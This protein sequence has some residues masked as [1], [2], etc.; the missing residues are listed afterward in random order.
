[1]P[2]GWHSA[3][4]RSISARPK[5]EFHPDSHSE[6]G[7]HRLMSAQQV[8]AI[9]ARKVGV[10]GFD[11]KG[12]SLLVRAQLPNAIIVGVAESDTDHGGAGSLDD[13]RRP[14]TVAV[15]E[16]FAVGRQQ[17][18]QSAFLLRPRR[19]GRRRTRGVRGRGW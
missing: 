12:D 9:F 4:P 18:G 14:F 15:D 17:L 1:M 3:R 19:R 8:D 7:I 2:G 5:P 13:P 6:Q 16:E 10:G 11:L